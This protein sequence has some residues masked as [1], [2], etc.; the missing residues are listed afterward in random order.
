[1]PAA[2]Q[3]P[4]TT[5]DL[6]RQRKDA[7][8]APWIGPAAHLAGERLR[9]DLT[10]AG[11]LPKVTMDWS[12]GAPSGKGPGAA[13]LNPTEAALA[14]RQRVEKA[15]AAVGPDFSGLLIDVCGFDKGLEQLESERIWPV[16]SAKVVVR[17]ALAALARHYGYCDAA[18]G[19]GGHGARSWAEPGSR[20]RILSRQ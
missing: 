7:A 13:G 8:G 1:M 15:L 5:L 4:A 20:A 18:T 9:A 14:A 19:R 6:M 11:I 16:R 12:R 2:A 17:L 3:S 10:F